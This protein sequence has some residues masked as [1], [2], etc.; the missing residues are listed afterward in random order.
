MWL[1]ILCLDHLYSV[2]LLIFV[3]YIYNFAIFKKF[4]PTVPFVPFY[5]F[6]F[7]LDW[8]IFM[9]ALSAP[10][11]WL[12]GYYFLSSCFSCCFRVCGIHVWLITVYFQA[13]LCY[14]MCCRWI[15]Q[16]YKFAPPSQNFVLFF[17]CFSSM[18][19]IHLEIYSYFIP[20][21]K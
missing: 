1:L 6:F 3:M 20:L 18:Y 19:V 7:S 8:S 11:F 12:I 2:W 14:L 10:F 21:H 5:F 9:I 17:I 16:Q 13:I 4:I 15:L